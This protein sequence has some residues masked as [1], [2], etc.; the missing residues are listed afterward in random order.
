[1]TTTSDFYAECNPQNLPDFGDAYCVKCFQ[2]ECSRS[3]VN[4]TSFEGRVRNWEE[5]LFTNPSRISE[6]DPNY[7]VL[8]GTKFVNV[9]K[10][11][12][13]AW[14][15]PKAVEADPA[16]EPEPEP[17]PVLSPAPPPVV[18]T[19]GVQSNTPNRPKQMVGG[20]VSLPVLDPWQAKKPLQPG[21]ALV[22][23]GAKVRLS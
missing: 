23:H 12:G 6:D 17:A 18:P 8:T 16:P 21:E 14:I 4:K 9:P 11:A 2:R 15:D 7:A 1:M 19:P 13:A 5:R 22:P 20:Q 3:I 10:T